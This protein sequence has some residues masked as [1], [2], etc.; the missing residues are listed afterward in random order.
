M[1][2]VLLN[3]SNE[4]LHA[5]AIFSNEMLHALILV[6]NMKTQG[7]V[8]DVACIIKT[9]DTPLRPKSVY[10]IKTAKI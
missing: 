9:R 6:M 4:M 2:Q 5:S 7:Q 1:M 3:F 8:Q 10:A